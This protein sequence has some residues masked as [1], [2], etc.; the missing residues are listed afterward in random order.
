MTAI[1]H[2]GH[3]TCPWR[4]QGR[5]WRSI[6]DGHKLWRPHQ[7]RLQGMWMSLTDRPSKSTVWPW[8]TLY[9]AVIV[10]VVAVTDINCGRHWFGR[11][12]LWPSWT[13]MWPLS[14]FPDGHISCR[15]LAPMSSLVYYITLVFF[16]FNQPTVP[17]L[18]GDRTC[19]PYLEQSASTRHVRTL[20]VCFLRMPEAFLFRRSFPWLVAA[21]CVVPAQWLSPFLDTLIVLFTYLL[22][23]R[24]NFSELLWQVFNKPDALPVIDQQCKA[25][26]GKSL[27]NYYKHNN[28]HYYYTTSFKTIRDSDVPRISICLAVYHTRAPC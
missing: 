12:S 7:R 10:Y 4:P 26:E 24:E 27:H 1:N 3:T 23:N 6:H 5:L 15:H 13:D 8:L 22:Q 16:V 25:A 20:Y 28:N 11:H 21:T 9:V 2:D 17:E 18:L 19:C 14:S